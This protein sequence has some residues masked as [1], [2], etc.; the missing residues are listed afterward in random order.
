MFG[1]RGGFGLGFLF[2]IIASGF[3]GYSIGTLS[4][5]FVTSSVG[6]SGSMVPIASSAV[7]A[8]FGGAIWMVGEII[9]A[10]FRFA[11]RDSILVKMI[12]SLS[13]STVSV[14][15]SELHTLGVHSFA[16]SNNSILA[17][18]PLASGIGSIALGVHGIIHLLSISR[19]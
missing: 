17:Y 13:G 11:E 14:I 10:L 18:L 12:L 4:P 3:L 6:V 15:T 16:V 8:L 5:G 19:K 9:T 7:T 1:H 2:V